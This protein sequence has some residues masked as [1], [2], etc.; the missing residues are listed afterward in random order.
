MRRPTICGPYSSL[1]LMDKEPEKR[2]GWGIIEK[3]MPHGARAQDEA[4]Q[5]VVRLLDVLAEIEER[6]VR[7]QEEQRRKLQQEMFDTQYLPDLLN[8]L[9]RQ[10]IQERG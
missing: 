10:P 7:K 3:Y 9:G 5:K 2:P 8:I 1:I 4:D 6:L